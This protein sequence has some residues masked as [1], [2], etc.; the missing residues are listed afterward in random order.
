[1]HSIVTSKKCKLAP[2]NLAM[3]CT[4]TSRS[5]FV[6]FTHSVFSRLKHA[7]VSCGKRFCSRKP[8]EWILNT[9]CV[10]KLTYSKL[11]IVYHS[12]T[13]IGQNRRKFTKK[14][15]H[16]SRG[17]REI[18][19]KSHQ[20]EQ[21]H[22]RW[23][24]ERWQSVSEL[25]SAH[26]CGDCATAAASDD[27]NLTE[28]AD[29]VHSTIILCLAIFSFVVHF[30]NSRCNVTCCPLVRLVTCRRVLGLWEISWQLAP[31]CWWYT[32]WLTA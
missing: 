14:L 22:E 17:A 27:T 23:Q 21:R 3:P 9:R 12:T 18:R 19:K 31:H 28:G 6:I 30:I 16:K 29:S 11:N 13:Y 8:I 4:C 24:S 5:H 20:W 32:L 1:M 15:H 7:W 26:G 25:R 10:Q 2:F